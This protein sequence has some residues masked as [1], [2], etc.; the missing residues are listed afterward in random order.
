MAFRWLCTSLATVHVSHPLNTN[1][2]STNPWNPEQTTAILRA[3]SLIQEEQNSLV[4][5]NSPILICFLLSKVIHSYTSS[6]T[7]TTLCFLQRSATMVSSSLV[8]TCHNKIIILFFPP[9]SLYVWSYNLNFL[10]LQL[11]HIRYSQFNH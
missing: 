9:V 1:K 8:K 7:H 5:M 4:E 6:A 3:D 2:I 10:M 11:L